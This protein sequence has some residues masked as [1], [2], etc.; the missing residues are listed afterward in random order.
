MRKKT[1]NFSQLNCNKFLYLNLNTTMPAF[2]LNTSSSDEYDVDGCNSG[3][4]S[5]ANTRSVESSKASAKSLTCMPKRDQLLTPRK[6]T[7]RKNECLLE[8]VTVED[9][10][11]QKRTS[12]KSSRMKLRSS[13]KNKKEEDVDPSRSRKVSFAHSKFAL[14]KS[15]NVK[16]NRRTPAASKPQLDAPMAPYPSQPLKP[17]SICPV[18]A[19][20]HPLPL[21]LF[22]GELDSDQP[23]ATHT[24]FKEPLSYAQSPPI[25][26]GIA[27]MGSVEL[28]GIALLDKEQSAKD[29][30]IANEQVKNF[31]PTPFTSMR[32][33]LVDEL[34]S[35]HKITEASYTSRKQLFAG[36]T[37]SLDP[38][39][40]DP[41]EDEDKAAADE[42][43]EAYNMSPN[44]TQ[45]SDELS[46]VNFKSTAA[47]YNAPGTNESYESALDDGVI[48]RKMEILLDL[49]YLRAGVKLSKFA[50]N[51]ADRKRIMLIL[52]NSTRAKLLI[53]M[54]LRN[55]KDIELVDLMREFDYFSS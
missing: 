11:E 55:N 21:R 40:E 4:R 37:G 15:P 50:I 13:Y 44:L 28:P 7:Q 47:Q 51:N 1:T 23:L 38:R 6:K 3:K 48:T 46:R 41:N 24:N 26:P 49:S 52:D 54:I 30:D 31:S 22:A 43:V 16:Y 19:I 53:A 25:S 34:D 35:P 45:L 20:Q 10:S 18:G 27:L 33:L 14:H 2:S 29:E 39:V 32:P 5:K 17:P 12:L 36:E 42:R 8:L 9:N